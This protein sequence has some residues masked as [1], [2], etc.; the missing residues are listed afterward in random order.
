MPPPPSRAP[1]SAASEQRSCVAP[2]RRARPS[3]RGSCPQ[4]EPDHTAVDGHHVQRREH[5]DCAWLCPSASTPVKTTSPRRSLTTTRESPPIAA[6]RTWPLLARRRRARLVAGTG[7]AQAGGVL[8]G[9]PRVRGQRRCSS[10]KYFATPQIST[11]TSTAAMRPPQFAPDAPPRTMPVD[12]VDSSASK[13]ARG[14][15]G[16]AA[17]M[18]VVRREQ[19]RPGRVRAPGASIRRWPRA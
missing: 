6:I 13:T 18:L 8:G 1:K 2:A 19:R 14:L 16:E 12:P 10:A 9:G 7:R 4:V 15:I 3:A 17:K 11:S 5:L